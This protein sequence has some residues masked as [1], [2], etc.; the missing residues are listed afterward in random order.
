MSFLGE[1]L[2]KTAIIMIIS[3]LKKKEYL[4]SKN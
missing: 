3:S 2:H 4:N 1:D